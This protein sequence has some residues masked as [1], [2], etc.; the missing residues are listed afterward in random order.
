MLPNHGDR[1]GEEQQEGRPTRERVEAR[2]V[3]G[4]NSSSRASALEHAHTQW[5]RRTSSR[6]VPR[7]LPPIPARIADELGVPVSQV[8][9]AI[10]LLDEGATVPFI[11]R[12]RKERT[13]GLDDV[14]LRALEERQHFLEGVEER[15]EKI[16]A[17]IDEQGKL[18][19]QLRKAI[20]AA[21][22]KTRLEDLYRP[23][24]V[25]RRTKAQIARENG[26]APLAEGLLA[27]PSQEPQAAA[28]AYVNAEAG[29]ADEA[30]AL[31]GARQI[32]MES[33]AEDADLSAELRDHVWNEGRLRSAV[34][35]GKEN[36]GARF[37]DYF[38]Y[39][40]PLSKIPSHRALALLRAR[41]EDVVSTNLLLDPEDARLGTD[42][43]GDPTLASNAVPLTL[44]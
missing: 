2:V 33:F 36:E 18:T 5:T 26:L 24:M 4:A 40:E 41:K 19:P 20:E 25:K 17:A 14:Q 42:T 11:A 7:V 21:E 23:Y 3:P 1:T 31:E 10:E 15:R 22:T 37:S 38:D 8:T 9:A 32:L 43:T 35:E 16:L 28:T 34:V 39:T 29:V 27:D 12:Y 6:I 30:A 44:L 13:G